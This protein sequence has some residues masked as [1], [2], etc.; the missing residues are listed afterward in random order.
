MGLI[1]TICSN[2]VLAFFLLKNV[3]LIIS[4]SWKKNLGKS[5]VQ[6]NTFEKVFSIGFNIFK[7]LISFFQEVEMLYYIAYGTLAI[8]GV[9]MH[10]FFFT[11]HLTEIMMRYP[12]LKNIL[13]SVYEPRSQLILTFMLY[14][15]I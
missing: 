8:L 9:I 11:F 5:K 14:M 10:P 7:I 2:F 15:I 13:K 3:P 12:S 6:E 1:M 4:K